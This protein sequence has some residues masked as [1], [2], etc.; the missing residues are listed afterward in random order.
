MAL[1]RPSG[2]LG[3][4]HLPEMFK[5]HPLTAYCDHTGESLVIRLRPRRARSNTASDQIEVL[6]EAI[7]RI[8]ASGAGY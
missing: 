7:E 4:T 3:G 6:T 5:C 8:P 1:S 2:S